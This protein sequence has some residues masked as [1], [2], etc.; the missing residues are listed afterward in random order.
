MPGSRASRGDRAMIGYAL[1]FLCGF[2]LC[3]DAVDTFLTRDGIKNSN[4]KIIEKNRW[5]VWWM[6]SDFRAWVLF[7]IDVLAGIAGTYLAL[8][9]SLSTFGAFLFWGYILMMKIGVCIKNYKIN[10]MI[11]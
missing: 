10:M 6:A 8:L 4:G 2:C 7:S 1:F 3:L 5:M 9:S 11:L